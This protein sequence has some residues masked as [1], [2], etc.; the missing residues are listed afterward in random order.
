MK[1]SAMTDFSESS[2]DDMP[3]KT[4][5]LSNNSLLRADANLPLHSLASFPTI[6]AATSRPDTFGCGGTIRT[7]PFALSAFQA[8]PVEASAIGVSDRLSKDGCDSGAALRMKF[9]A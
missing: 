7:K 5:S 8:A 4:T 9:E 2:Q 3:R 6:A 1:Y